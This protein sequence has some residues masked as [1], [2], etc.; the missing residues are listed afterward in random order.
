MDRLAYFPTPLARF[1]VVP[2]RV[3]VQYSSGLPC[4]QIFN[5]TLERLMFA[6]G[7]LHLLIAMPAVNL[8]QVAT[9]GITDGEA[10]YGYFLLQKL[11]S[12]QYFIGHQDLEQ[13]THVGLRVGVNELYALQK[14]VFTATRVKHKYEDEAIRGS[15]IFSGSMN[16]YG[17]NV[18]TDVLTIVNQR[19]IIFTG[20]RAKAKGWLTALSAY[21]QVESFLPGAM[22]QPMPGVT[23]TKTGEDEVLINAFGTKLR[24]SIEA[25]VIIEKLLDGMWYEDDDDDEF[26]IDLEADDEDEEPLPT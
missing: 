5:D 6:L 9:V 7:R 18:T 8:I 10:T 2:G 20:Q 17:F 12:E 3:E 22:Y 24:L 25:C 16:G 15:F 1:L 26:I 4:F 21:D 14:A 13:K 23:V 11:S 19:G